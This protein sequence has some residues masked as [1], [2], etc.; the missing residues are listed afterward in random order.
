MLMHGGGNRIYGRQMMIHNGEFAECGV[1]ENLL[2]GPRTRTCGPR[3]S[4][5]TRTFLEDYKFTTLRVTM[6]DNGC[7]AEITTTDADVHTVLYSRTL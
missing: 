7:T 1:L 5:R 6:T 4:S 2:C 3:G